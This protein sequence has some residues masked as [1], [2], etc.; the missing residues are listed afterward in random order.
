MV[1]V[2]LVW[3]GR[4]TPF[5]PCTVLAIVNQDVLPRTSSIVCLSMSSVGVVNYQILY[6]AAPCATYSLSLLAHV[7]RCT[8]P[9][10]CQVMQT[11][12]LSGVVGHPYLRMIVYRL[13][14]CNQQPHH[15]QEAPCK[16]AWWCHCFIAEL[17][18]EHRSNKYTQA[19]LHSD[20]SC[21]RSCYTISV[22]VQSPA[23][24]LANPAGKHLSLAVCC[25]C[26]CGQG[27]GRH[28]K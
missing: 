7:D 16:C 11:W 27:L 20:N 2:L 6:T 13:H 9:G 26:V 18:L 23:H 17:L 15:D 24:F 8:C 1:E 21:W 4:H 22:A 5:F 10:F 3:S 12:V 28:C 19:A 14:R 25:C